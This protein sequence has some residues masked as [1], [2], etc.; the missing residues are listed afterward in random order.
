M[1]I[2]PASDSFDAF[3]N[4]MTRIVLSFPGWSNGT[5]ADRQ[6][7]LIGPATQPIR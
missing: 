4:T 3:T 7:H 6:P 5:A 1:G 2:S